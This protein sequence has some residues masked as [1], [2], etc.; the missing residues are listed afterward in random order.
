MQQNIQFIFS[1]YDNDLRKQKTMDGMR[2]KLLRGEWLGQCPT[3]YEYEKIG[4]GKGQKIIVNEKG[5]LIK[6][7][8]N[9]KLM[10]YN[11]K[12]ITKKLND[13]GLKIHNQLLTDIFQNPFYCGFMANNL[14]NGE[15][16]KGNHPALITEEQF[17]KVNGLK[18]RG[19]YKQ[20]K[21]NS[22]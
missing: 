8:F 17:L 7:A 5:A 22:K 18:D 21:E 19:G 10:G 2:E 6:Q 3:G 15:V 20:N 14:L 9:W 16:L 13:L 11:N 12:Q 4:G 1:K